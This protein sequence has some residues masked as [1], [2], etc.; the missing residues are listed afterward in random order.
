MPTQGS[1][2]SST[3]SSNS[4]LKMNRLGSVVKDRFSVNRVPE[5]NLTAP[6]SPMRQKAKDVNEFRSLPTDIQRADNLHYVAD[7]DGSLTTLCDSTDLSGNS[8]ISVMWTAVPDAP[9]VMAMFVV[10]VAAVP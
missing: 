2:S 8:R 9:L 7:T 3:P 10:N 6:A 4:P 5:K 1:A